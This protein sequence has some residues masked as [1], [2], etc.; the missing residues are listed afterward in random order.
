MDFSYIA[1]LL[2]YL[3]VLFVFS[4]YFYLATEDYE[5]VT[6][7]EMIRRNALIGRSTGWPY[8]PLA[9]YLFYLYSL[10][11]G[12]SVLGF[13]LLTAL[14]ILV[15]TVPVYLTLRTIS[16]PFMAFALTLLSYSLSTFPH[17]RLEYFVEGAIAAFAIYFGVKFLQTD[18]RAYV[19][20]CAVFAFLA[21]ASRGHPNSSALLFLLP[22]SLMIVPWIIASRDSWNAAI[23]RLANQGRFWL[24]QIRPNLYSFIVVA[25]L[26][27]AS[28]VWISRFLREVLYRRLFVYYADLNDLISTW[29]K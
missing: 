23:D 10:G 19:Y 20:C 28:F 3:G 7:V 11:F 16:D 12:D 14:L 18:R 2:A 5:A 13:R 25:V 27:I 8:T 9:G 4:S 17:P 22:F 21:F 1:L 24:T 29:I 6:A 15:A 26:T